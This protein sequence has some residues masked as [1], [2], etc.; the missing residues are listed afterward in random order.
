MAGKPIEFTTE[1]R[2]MI[3]QLTAVGCTIDEVRLCIPWPKGK[4]PDEKTLRK[5]C[6][7][8]LQRGHALAH[9]RV[10]KRLFD[11]I[12]EGN[13][14]ATIFYLKARC[15]WSEV[16]KLEQTG[17]DGAPL[18]PAT[19]VVLPQKDARP[20]E[21]PMVRIGRTQPEPLPAPAVA[22]A[23]PAS[24]PAAPAAPS[25]PAAPPELKKSAY[26]GL[27]AVGSLWPGA[28]DRI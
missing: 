18:Q 15:G 19:V 12:E 23:E 5:H 4:A 24:A 25:A 8:E 6:E 26:G 7:P 20:E 2:K 28:A 1:Q 16:V 14:A 3:E 17:K 9:M 21:Q 10:K 22:R 11:L 13:V 27:K